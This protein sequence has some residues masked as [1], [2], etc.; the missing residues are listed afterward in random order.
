M[1]KLCQRSLTSNEWF[2]G[3]DVGHSSRPKLAVVVDFHWKVVM[4]IKSCVEAM[5]KWIPQES[6]KRQS[7]PSDDREING[8]QSNTWKNYNP[9]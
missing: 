4:T 9:Y 6:W 8:G 7:R 1:V 5:L 2:Q 3:E